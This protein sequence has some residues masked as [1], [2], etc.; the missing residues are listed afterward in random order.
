MKRAYKL[1]AAAAVALSVFMGPAAYAEDTIRFGTAPEP[2]PPFSSK[3]ASG[4][5]VGWEIELMDAVCAQMKAKCQ[6][7]E[8]S[9][10]GLIPA[11]NAKQIDVIWNSMSITDERK[12]VIDFTNKYYN[13]PAVV[14]GPK[15]VKF[16]PNP[17]D[18]KGKTVGVQVSTIHENYVKKYFEPAGATVKSYQTQDEAN[19]DLA[20]GRIDAI[21]ADAVALDAFLQSDQGKQ[22]CDL[23]GAVK[24]DPA[25]LGAGVGGGVRKDDTALK[26]KLNAA[27]AAV[28]ADGTYKKISDKYFAFDIYGPATGN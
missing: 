11:L 3:D 7:V 17:E 19:Q 13:T 14:I 5:W 4:K 8:I 21:M 9:W 23:K 20:A 1:A 18:M 12:K 2:Y 22:C 25:I 24:D 27:I 10:D 28:R 26:D 15:D 6:I 16:G